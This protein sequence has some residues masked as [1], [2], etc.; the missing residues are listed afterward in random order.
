LSPFAARPDNPTRRPPGPYGRR[1]LAHILRLYGV[2]VPADD[3]RRLIATLLADRGDLAQSAAALITRG[4]EFNLAAIALPVAEREAILAVLEEPE[5]ARRAARPALR[6]RCS[7]APQLARE[8]PTPG[9][10]LE[11]DPAP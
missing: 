11:Q 8:P 2:P 4:L 3:A 7:T 10:R 6:R 9:P 1:R 5:R